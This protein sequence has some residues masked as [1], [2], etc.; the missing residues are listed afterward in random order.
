MLLYNAAELRRVIGHQPCQ[1]NCSS[2]ADYCMAQVQKTYEETKVHGQ[3]AALDEVNYVIGF[4]NLLCKMT[5]FLKLTEIDPAAY[6]CVRIGLC[7]SVSCIQFCMVTF[8]C[9]FIFTIRSYKCFI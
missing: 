8:N 5:L 2:C 1:E 6:I 7:Y 3:V 9:A 4:I